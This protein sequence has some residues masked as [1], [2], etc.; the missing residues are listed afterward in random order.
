MSP[1]TINLNTF[2]TD[3][4]VEALST[5]TKSHAHSDL[6]QSLSHTSP[7]PPPLS[8]IAT[9]PLALRWMRGSPRT[10]C[11]RRT[12]PIYMWREQAIIER[13][14]WMTS[15]DAYE[16]GGHLVDCTS[17][18]QRRE[19]SRRR[20]NSTVACCHSVKLCAHAVRAFRSQ[21]HT[22]NNQFSLRWPHMTHRS[23]TDV[24]FQIPG[25]AWCSRSRTSYRT[26]TAGVG[27]SPIAESALVPEG[28]EVC[29]GRMERWFEG[30]G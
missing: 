1:K 19:W 29:D 2:T 15:N 30:S 24:P 18:W 11:A 17:W 3:N 27:I 13:Y 6:D 7:I 26:S 25:W 28:G 4:C 20:V 23:E 9:S 22:V 10:E 21:Q 14:W 12:T 16:P 8:T 5:T